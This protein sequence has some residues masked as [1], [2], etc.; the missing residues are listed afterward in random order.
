[1]SSETPV[2]L[3]VVGL[4]W[5]GKVLAGAANRSGRAEI[6]AC[7]AR[8]EAT[9]EAA[10][11]ELGCRS[12]PTFAA[13]AG[14]DDIE[15]VILATPHTIHCDQIC[16]LAAA[17][18]HV[19]VEKPFTLTVAEARRATEAAAAAGVVLAVGHQR[20]HQAA[21]R[22]IRQ[23]IDAGDLGTPL[24]AA[25]MFNVSSGYPDTWRATREE[26]PLGGMTGLGVH[27]IDTFHYLLGP[28]ERVSAFSNPVL[29]EAPLD[30]ATGCVFEFESGAVGTLLTSHFLPKASSLSVHGS[31]GAAYNED[32]GARL[33]FQN[34]SDPVRAEIDVEPNDAVVDQLVAF[35]DAIRGGSMIETDG[36]V[37]LAVV[38]VLQ[39]AVASA[40]RGEVVEVAELED[41]D[42]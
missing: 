34:L 39:A 10:A 19:F 17:G 20:R 41:G 9:R 23:L 29:A 32:D 8:T 4:G 28:I 22:R 11:T 36:W 42:R 6:V 1:M 16:E 31:E 26:T 25:S 7:H 33:F 40:E 30:H 13:M 38:A 15:G 14:A 12:E 24:V 2:R 3:G 5:W 37:G 27:M 18:K 35:T 21:N